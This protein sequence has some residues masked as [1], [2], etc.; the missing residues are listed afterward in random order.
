[1]M[2]NSNEV[3]YNAVKGTGM[4]AEMERPREVIAPPRQYNHKRAIRGIPTLALAQIMT[5]SNVRRTV[6]LC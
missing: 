2:M 1:M 6:E 4:M 3:Q 5:Q